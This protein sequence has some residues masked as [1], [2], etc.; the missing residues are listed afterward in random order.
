LFSGEISDL[1]SKFLGEQ[2]M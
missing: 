2:P 1:Q